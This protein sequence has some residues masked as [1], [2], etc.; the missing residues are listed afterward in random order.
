M[1]KS[2]SKTKNPKTNQLDPFLRNSRVGP[3]G[4]I[5]TKRLTLLNGTN[6]A[7]NGSGFV[8]VTNYAAGDCQSATEWSSFAAR[9]QQFRV[10]ALR[11]TLTPLFPKSQFGSSG[12]H[13]TMVASDASGGS[14]PSTPS[15]VFSDERA[16]LF[17][18]D[19][20]IVFETTW[21]RNPNAS[22]WNVTSGAMPIANNYSVAVASSAQVATSLTSN[23]MSVSEEWIVEFKGSQ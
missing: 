13:L 3:L 20:R 5:V 9:Y 18:T 12:P 22:L 6:L 16:R 2:A 23:I 17:S 14:Y 11:I 10:K 19:T 1:K 8:P 7:T 21:S 4:D 15:Q